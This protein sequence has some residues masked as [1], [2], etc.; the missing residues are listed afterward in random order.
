MSILPPSDPKR[1][2][3]TG[4][5]RP[6]GVRWLIIGAC[7]LINAHR[8]SAQV[9]GQD[10]ALKIEDAVGASTII[11]PISV[12]PDGEWVAYTLQDPRRRRSPGES[13]RLVFGETGAPQTV[14]ACDVWVASTRTGES[15]NLGLN[16]ASS[17]S[18]KWSPDGRLL[19][20]YSDRG[21]KVGLWTWELVNRLL[22][23]VPDVAPR[24]LF[25]W[26]VVEWLPDS[27][28]VVLKVVAAKG[29]HIAAKIP[30]PGGA[31]S[32]D[33]LTRTAVLVY[34]SD[35]GPPRESASQAPAATPWIDDSYA[36]V[37]VADIRTGPVQKLASSVRSKG[38][39]LAPSGAHLAISIYSGRKPGTLRHEL[40]DIVILSTLDGTEKGVARQVPQGFM[41]RSMSW[42]P[43]SRTLA[44]V[45]SGPYGVS[46]STFGE[47][48][49]L[50]VG[51][52]TP[53]RP[54]RRVR[55]FGD[56]SD[57][58][59]PLW[60]P[61]GKGLL[62]T[63]A[64]TLWEVIPHTGQTR[65]LASFPHSA[66]LGVL[67]AD[68]GNRL[69]SGPG[70][71]S[72]YVRVRDR[73]SQQAVTY[74]VGLAGGQPARTF[75]G[76]VFHGSQPELST[77]ASADGSLVAYTAQAAA[78]G[79]DI[80]VSQVGGVTPR[81]LTNINP[82]LRQY[83]LSRSQLV[84]WLSSDGE[85]VNGALLLPV[86]YIPGKRYPLVVRVYG[87]LR[88]SELLNRFSVA[89]DGVDNAHLF[90][91]RGYA[92]LLPDAPYRTGSTL[93]RD[94][95][96]SVIPGVTRV[97]DM[98]IADTGRIGLFGHSFGG[99][100]ALA[101]LVQSRVFRAAVASA[102]TGNLVATFGVLDPGVSSWVEEGQLGMNGTPWTSRDRYIE[103]SPVFYLDRVEAPLLLVSGS[104]DGLPP[105]LAEEVYVGLKRLGKQVVYAKYLGEEHYEGEWSFANKVDYVRRVLDWF[106]VQL[107]AVEALP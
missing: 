72:V 14:T 67:A 33:S 88:Y 31:R 79:E 107:H 51:D 86:G 103:N 104:L 58:R 15:I 52:S 1:P 18:P 85:R 6:N 44:F 48:L 38:M 92:V 87:G 77:D 10:T 69:L 30:I 20:F 32:R 78:D 5:A 64:D 11:P 16:T 47:L 90:T 102:A 73:R 91:T 100:T 50:A 39:A 41:G 21:G 57:G 75:A 9:K 26:D 8:T 42:S 27:R 40:F 34:R 55:S 83:Q 59:P 13:R 60:L 96:A 65:V 37:V 29:Q 76:A 93:M 35:D 99:Y 66:V 68:R 80:W 82:E 3:R 2:G 53:L 95:A 101:L 70:R 94:L 24:P 62:V 84:S 4:R 23:R 36:D 49:L 63:G 98:G 81:R 106:R 89:G 43:D 17:W 45:T 74:E 71:R 54:V 46:D 22:R 12:S 56:E 25:S 105:H 61:S 97:I 28:R 7:C 19:A